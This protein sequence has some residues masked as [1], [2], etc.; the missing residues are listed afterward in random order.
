VL[1]LREVLDEPDA[2]E[3]EW[4]GA[5]SEEAVRACYDAVWVYGDPAVYDP[6]REYRFSPAVAA[7]VRYTGYLDA[8]ARLRSAAPGPP[9]DLG[10]PTGPLVLCTVG[11]GQDGAALAEAFAAADLPGGAGGVILTGPFMPADARQRLHRRAAGHPRLRVL[12]FV[13]E[14]GRLL[15]RAD[16]VIAMGGYNT[17]CEV[18]SFEKDALIVPRVRPRREQLIRAERLR[19]LGLVDVL[20]PDTAT[21]CALAEWLARDL[22]PRPPVRDRVDLDGLARLPRLLEALL[23]AGPPCPGIPPRRGRGSGSHAPLDRGRGEPVA[24]SPRP[25]RA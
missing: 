8:R 2:V 11:G 13:A 9:D 24:T 12:E 14:P 15:S 1:G 6:V 23:G 3:R 10:L 22:P 19:D 25:D 21:P 20:H 18:L 17:V 5:G 16:R 7:K 4:R